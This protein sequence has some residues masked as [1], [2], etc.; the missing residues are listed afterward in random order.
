MTKKTTRADPGFP[1][2]RGHQPSRGVPT[3]DFAKFYK[4]LLE[5]EKILG[6]GG[7]RGCPPKSATELP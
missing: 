4:K 2:G 3:Y 1:V 5:I 6:H 7:R